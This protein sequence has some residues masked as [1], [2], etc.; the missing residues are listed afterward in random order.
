LGGRGRQIS[1]FKASL[2]YRVSY[3]TARATQRNPVSTN[4][5]TNKQTNNQTKQNKNDETE[6]IQQGQGIEQRSRRLS[7][8][9]LPFVMSWKLKLLQGLV[10]PGPGRAVL[11]V[12]LYWQRCYVHYFTCCHDKNLTEQ[13]GEGR[14][15][16]GRR[17]EG[18]VCFDSWLKR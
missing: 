9:L 15:R 5:Q 18:S 6:Q 13:L 16:E 12:L 10:D 14:G 4:K 1:E 17:G 7:P 8:H 11:G 2:V 3:R